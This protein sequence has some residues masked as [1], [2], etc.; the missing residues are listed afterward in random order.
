MAAGDDDQSVAQPGMGMYGVNVPH[1]RFPKHSNAY[2]LVYVR[3]S[4][5]DR[6]ICPVN[7]VRSGGEGRQHGSGQGGV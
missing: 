6:I 2:M 4:D 1:M 5:W 7:K 3:L